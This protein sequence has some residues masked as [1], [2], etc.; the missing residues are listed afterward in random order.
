MLGLKLI[1]VSK[2]APWAYH[3]IQHA[4]EMSFNGIIL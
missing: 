3:N 1:H 2:I 4:P